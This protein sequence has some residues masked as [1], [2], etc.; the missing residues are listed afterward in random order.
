MYPYSSSEFSRTGYKSCYLTWNSNDSEDMG[1]YAE[2]LSYCQENSFYKSSFHDYRDGEDD[3]PERAYL[4]YQDLTPSHNASESAILLG[5]YFSH[6]AWDKYKISEGYDA[7]DDRFNG[8]EMIKDSSDLVGWNERW[9]RTMVQLN[10]SQNIAT[11]GN[12]GMRWD[13][14]RNFL[15]TSMKC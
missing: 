13:Y 7:F 4:G 11:V 12:H 3:V 14:M 5:D 9:M 10:S 15:A 8:L 2:P 6:F 1:F